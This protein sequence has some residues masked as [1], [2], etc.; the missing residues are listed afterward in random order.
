MRWRAHELAK[1]RQV[2][3]R[4][5]TTR[6]KRADYCASVIT[7][8]RQYQQ[9]LHRMATL[10]PAWARYTGLQPG[11]GGQPADAAIAQAKARGL[12]LVTLEPV[13]TRPRH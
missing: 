9:Q 6:G 11:P 3:L 10:N 5:P 2:L 7:D 13:L 8:D 4:A 1:R 12:T